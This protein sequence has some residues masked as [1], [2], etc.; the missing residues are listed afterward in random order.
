MIDR[1][2][3]VNVKSE[4]QGESQQGNSQ[5]Y[6]QNSAQMGQNDQHRQYLGEAKSEF[7]NF[8]NIDF[9]SSTLPEGTT[10]NDFKNFQC[11]FKEHCEV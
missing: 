5:S 2:K 11:L 3:S 8:D 6:Q 10:E 4:G 1:F 7:P 9:G